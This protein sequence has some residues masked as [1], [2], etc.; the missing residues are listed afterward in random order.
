VKIWATNRSNRGSIPTF[1]IES[2]TIL[3]IA[4][5]EKNNDAINMGL[6]FSACA[7]LKEHGSSSR[8]HKSGT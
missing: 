4:W 2:L 7:Y 1:L 6:Y 3:Q 5:D 8:A